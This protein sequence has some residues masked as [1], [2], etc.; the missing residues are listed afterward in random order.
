MPLPIS[1]DGRMGL[2]EEY[3]GGK[4]GENTT[5]STPRGFSERLIKIAKG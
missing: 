3:S 4:D 2:P 5:P 1:Q